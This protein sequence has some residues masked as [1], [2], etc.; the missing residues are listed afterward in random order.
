[1]LIY[2]VGEAESVST[3]WWFQDIVPV[4]T[5]STPPASAPWPPSRPL[6]PRRSWAMSDGHGEFHVAFVAFKR[7][8]RGSI[9]L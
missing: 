8:L 4:A 5:S 2:I 6:E 3:S 1:M 7:S 9:A